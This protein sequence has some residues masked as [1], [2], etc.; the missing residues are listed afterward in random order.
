[1]A[2]FISRVLET[3]NFDALP[4]VAA[5]SFVNSG[6]LVIFSIT[7]PNYKPARDAAKL[8]HTMDSLTETPARHDASSHEILPDERKRSAA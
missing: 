1:M 4:Q 2:P 7:P 6:R 8:L 3:R 5:D